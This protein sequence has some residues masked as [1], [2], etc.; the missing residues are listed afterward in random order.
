MRKLSATKFHLHQKRIKRK[1]YKSYN[2]F[3]QRIFEAKIDSNAAPFYAIIAYRKG[4]WSIWNWS[5]RK[6]AWKNCVR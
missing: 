1:E 3:K 4:A 6:S 2:S 5:K